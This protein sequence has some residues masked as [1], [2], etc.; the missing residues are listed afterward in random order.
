MNEL[1]TEL[2]AGGNSWENLKKLS[3][4]SGKLSFEDNVDYIAD[5]MKARIVYD[6]RRLMK[7]DNIS[8]IELARRMNK[9]RQYVS[10]ILS[11]SANFTLNTIAELAVA[12]KVKPSVQI[13]KTIKKPQLNIGYVASLKNLEPQK[14]IDIKIIAA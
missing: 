13:E 5:S 2:L 14:L 3:D 10:R 6:V 4:E 7:E 12:L 8:Q 1:L 9:S 11:E